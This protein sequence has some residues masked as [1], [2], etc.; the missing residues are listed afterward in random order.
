MAAVAGATSSNEAYGREPSIPVKAYKHFLTRVDQWQRQNRFAAPA[1]GVVKKFG[2]DGVSQFVVALGWYGFLAIYPLLLVVITVFGFIGVASL[3]HGIVST[4]HRFPVVGAQF[5]PA[6]PSGE[7]HGSIFCLTIGLL[8]MIYGAQGVTQTALDSMARIW[9][10]SSLDLPAFFPRLT[11]SLISLCI[12]GGSFLANAALSSLVTESGRSF[13]V[14]VSNSAHHVV[15][16]SRVFLCG[17]SRFDPEPDNYPFSVSRRRRRVGRIYAAH[18]CGIG[19]DSTPSP[20]Q[21]G[22]VWPVRHSYRPSCLS[23]STGEN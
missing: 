19:V 16:Q 8:G 7:L 11:R 17:I 2:D 23:F 22:N 10:I 5:N 15:H 6:N 4:L 21:L 14:R 9:N 3:G 13:P 18:Y 1:Y 20:E 12:I